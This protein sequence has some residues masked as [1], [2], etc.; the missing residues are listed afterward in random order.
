VQFDAFIKEL[1]MLKKSNDP[2]NKVKTDQLCKQNLKFFQI[3]RD[4]NQFQQQMIS[5]QQIQG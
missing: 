4:L 3:L 5:Q 2:R 1:D